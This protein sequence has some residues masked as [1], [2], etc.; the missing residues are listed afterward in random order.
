MASITPE[1]APEYLE[2]RGVDIGEVHDVAELA[3]G[4]SGVVLRVHGSRRDVVVKQALA[5]LRVADP[6]FASPERAQTEARAMSVYER[7]TPDGVPALLD[8]DAD[9]FAL[10]MSA[11]PSTWQ[12]WKAQLMQS[13]PDV[14]EAARVGA[15]LGGL[16]GEWHRQTHGDAD[17]AERFGDVGTFEVLRVDPFHRA[18][19]AKHPRARG[20]I[21]RCVQDLLERRDCLVHGD[22]SP[23]NVL[24]DPAGSDGLWVLDFE[25]A[26]VGAAVFDPAFLHAHLLLK[27]VH[28]NRA[29]QALSRIAQS[30]HEAYVRAAGAEISRAVETRLAWHIGCLLLARVDGVSTATYL[31]EDER[32]RVRSLALAVLHDDDQSLESIWNRWEG[33]RA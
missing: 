32:Q 16:L 3:G 9:E 24:V 15:R 30:V 31:T 17:L 6:W 4:V 23:K 14:D 19:A 1:T 33:D 7:I 25:V 29:D 20:A 5:Q 11:A 21:D 22:F 13:R 10:T 28:Q 26:R 27:S 12:T 2:R 18:V 8:S